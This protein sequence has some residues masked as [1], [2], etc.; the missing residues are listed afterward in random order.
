MKLRAAIFDVYGTLLEVGP[1]PPDADEQWT[2][3]CREFLGGPP[4]LELARFTAA[5]NTIVAREHATARSAGILHPE[6]CWPAVTREALPEL[7]RL[8]EAAQDEFLY[9]HAQRAH[10]VGLA[11]DAVETLGL[12][13]ARGV[14]LGIASN[15]QPYT[16]RELDTALAAA[17]L[18]LAVF[19]E[20]ICFWSFHHGFSKPDPHVFRLLTARLQALGIVARET[21]MVGDRADNDIEPAR[22]QGW[23][24]W[25]LTASPPPDTTGGTW[26][27]LH[28]HLA[29]TTM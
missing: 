9:R 29:T 8:A 7:A 2:A 23:Q 6:V 1:P 12:L 27:G 4:R 17:G 28:A 25:L 14:L 21:L 24:T 5:C 3:L 15:A 10:G 19:R 26:R 18:D 11:P 13:V 22:A 16:L 20:E